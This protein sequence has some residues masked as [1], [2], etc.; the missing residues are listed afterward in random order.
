MSIEHLKS[1]PD[2][3][4]V[5]MVLDENVKDRALKRAFSPYHTLALLF[6]D[7]GSKGLRYRSDADRQLNFAAIVF[8]VSM[9]AIEIAL[10]DGVF[11]SYD[12]FSYY[13][14]AL[15]GI[16]GVNKLQ[17]AQADPEIIPE[18]NLTKMR[19]W[20]KKDRTHSIFFSDPEAFGSLPQSLR[21]LIEYTRTMQ[22]IKS[23]VIPL[24]VTLAKTLPTLP[25]EEP[26]SVA[27]VVEIAQNM[28]VPI[29]ERSLREPKDKVDIDGLWVSFQ[30]SY[31]KPATGKNN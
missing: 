2:S 3:D 26:L 30:N 8:G 6:K 10:M 25:D 9:R 5:T 4:I 18:S 7:Q 27:Q 12:I 31:S 1:L 17:T 20:S 11:D 22:D 14:E 16:S 23:K 15:T 13:N 29:V 19:E 28:P 24:Y 21:T